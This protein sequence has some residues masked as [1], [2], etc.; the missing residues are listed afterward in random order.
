M[1]ITKALQ[2]NI[3][4]RRGRFTRAA[5]ARN[6]R[7]AKLALASSGH[8]Q[9]SCIH[10]CIGLPSHVVQHHQRLLDIPAQPAQGSQPCC[11]I[12][13]H[14]EHLLAQK[15]QALS[16]LE[17]ALLISLVADQHC[18]IEADKLLMEMVKQELKLVCNLS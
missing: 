13:A 8:V 7:D 15:V 2:G 11:A 6:R 9:S 4:H 1:V 10:G 12:M 5:L 14:P 3:Q 18:I 16:D 17:L